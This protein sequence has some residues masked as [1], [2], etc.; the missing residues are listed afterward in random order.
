MRV[1]QGCVMPDGNTQVLTTEGNEEVA[2]LGRARIKGTESV[3]GGSQSPQTKPKT[4]G[5]GNGGRAECVSCGERAAPELK[6]TV[7]TIPALTAAASF[8]ED[9][10]SGP[11]LLS[12]S[13]SVVLSAH[14]MGAVAESLVSWP[15]P[16][17]MKGSALQDPPPGPAAQ[18]CTR[19][20]H[21]PP[22][23]ADKL[24]CVYAL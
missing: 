11:R 13:L 18:R 23:I 15:G 16:W 17:K 19:R 3:V 2:S 10:G 9:P 22:G 12:R 6:A 7:G 8:T 5:W 21:G 1:S 20:V 4:S 24:F 14:V